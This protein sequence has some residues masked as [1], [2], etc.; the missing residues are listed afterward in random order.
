MIKA[1]TWRFSLDQSHFHVHSG[2]LCA[3]CVLRSQRTVAPAGGLDE[4][5]GTRT[6]LPR[7]PGRRCRHAVGSL[8][9]AGGGADAAF[10]AVATPFAEMIF[11]APKGI[12]GS[13]LAGMRQGCPVS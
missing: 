12:A 5:A 3:P 2:R 13:P 10:D 11:I 7:G 4:P 1:L 9:V 6:S 8:A